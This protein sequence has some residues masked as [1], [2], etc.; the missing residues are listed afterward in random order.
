MTGKPP[1]G[2]GAVHVSPLAKTGAITTTINE[3][4]PAALEKISNLAG[5]LGLAE[6]ALERFFTDIKQEHIP[7]EDWR[8]KLIEFA[9]R[10]KELSDRL[11]RYD[12]NDPIIAKSKANAK[13]AID[14]GEYQAADRHLAGA[15]Q[16]DLEIAG[17][18]SEAADKRRMDAAETRA[19]RAQA[20]LLQFD[21]Y[22]AATH[23]EEAFK[24][25]PKQYGPRKLNFL[26]DAGN[27][28]HEAAQY[29]EALALKE[30]AVTFAEQVHDP[31]HPSIATTLNNLAALYKALSRYE[32][33]EPLY[34]R[35]LEIKEKALGKDHPSVAITLNNL[36]AL[37]E[38]LS[39][40]EE[41]E[42]LYL[43]DLAIS[44]KALGKDHPS[45]AATLNNL[46]ELYKALSRYE[47][48]EPLYLRSLEIKEKALGKD[49]PE[50]ATTLNNLAGLYKAL[51]RYE[52]AEPLYLRSLEIKEKALGK[53]HPEV[54]ITLNNLA[55]LY[56]ALSRY[57]EA[58]PLYLRSLDILKSKLP[59]NHP[60]IKIVEA[61]FTKLKAAMKAQLG[62]GGE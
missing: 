43:R 8:S 38:A 33:A 26:V 31:D 37:Y 29:P 18:M 59:V 45:V 34:L 32:E 58:E 20:A 16:R 22:R 4:S 15:E 42:P 46:A 25:T 48:A 62:N 3:V 55:G 9:G 1:T 51:S 27:N 5:K 41:A 49:H 24:T 35:S 23:Y 57:E 52:E 54:A 50:V 21:Y 40:Y 2:D 19:E 60:D 30:Q 39:R 7:V 47:E 17:E 36:A 11:A 13:E 61:N 12:G 14:A 44:E 10:H 28:Y 53:D 6:A 56:E